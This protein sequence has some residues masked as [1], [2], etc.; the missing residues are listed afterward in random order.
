[1]KYWTVQK[2]ELIELARKEGSYQPDFK[3]SEYLKI[4]ADL[5]DLYNAVL[6]AYNHINSSNLTGLIYAFLRS[7]DEAVYQIENYEEFRILIKRKKSAIYSLWK[8]LMKN[9]VVVVE[10]DYEEKF[11]PLL[12]DINDFQFLMPPIRILPPYTEQ[13]IERILRELYT[14]QISRSI[15]PSNVI[16]AH[17]PY[18]K[19]ENITEIYPMFDID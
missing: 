9:D 6:E 11:N 17:L 3:K 12:I 18:I 13:D 7:D 4:N 8:Q 14:G 2:R 15:F 5:K 1:M 10:L 19:A 16:Q